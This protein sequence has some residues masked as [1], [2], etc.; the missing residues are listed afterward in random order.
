MVALMTGVPT[1]G[2]I[3]QQDHVAGGMSIDQLFLDRSPLLGGALSSSPNKTALGSLRLAA[4]IR[5]DRD[6]IAPRVMSYRPPL[7]NPDINSARQ[8]MF[9]E[10]QPLNAFNLLFGGALPPDTNVTDLLAQKLSVLDFMRS[11][12]TRMRRLIPAS[13]KPKLDIHAAAIQQLEATLRAA[14]TGSPRGGGCVT[15][16]TPPNFPLT[17]TGASGALGPPG[18]SRLRGADY[19]VAGDPTNHPHQVLGRTHLAIIRAAFLC[20]LV[21]VATFSWAPHG[22]WVVFPGAFGGVTLSLGGTMLASSPAH[23]PSNSLDPGVQAWLAA[24]DAFYADQTS[25]A[26]QEFA[27]ASDVDGNNLLDNTVIPY[28]SEV[29]R[30]WDHN[31]MNVPLAVFGGKNTRIKGGTFLKVTDG[32]LPMQTGMTTSGGTGNRPFNDVWLALAPIFGVNLSALGATTQYSGPL[33]GVITG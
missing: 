15:P 24:I 4:D 2:Q 30:A 32:T 27:S 21:R 33:P 31:Q 1:L 8:P 28:V 11:D 12:L 22:N 6:E 13:E 14:L 29:G 5:A 25:Q 16:P 23:P 18:G 17:G 10:N 19:F 3:G 20:D 26:I 7:A 9:P